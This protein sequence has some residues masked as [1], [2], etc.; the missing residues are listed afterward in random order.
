MIKLGVTGGIGSGKSIVCEFLSLFSIPVFNS[1]AMAKELMDNSESLR[2]GLVNLLGNEAYRSGVLDRQYVA[3]RIFADKKM[4]EKVN[5]IVHP[6]VFDCFDRWC[7]VHCDSPVVAC[8]SAILFECGMNR[9]MDK[10]LLV[11]AP[12]EE[13]IDRV[14]KR[15]GLKREQVLERIGNQMSDDLKRDKCDFVVTNGDVIPIIPQLLGVV[16]KIN[17]DL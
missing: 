8:E 1:D 13:R 15:S 3:E 9:L 6:A 12:L 16:K 14:I 2:V 11:T 5:S 10:T 7:E 17:P 4:V